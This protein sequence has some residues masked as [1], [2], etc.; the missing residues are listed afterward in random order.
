MG[1]TDKVAGCVKQ[2]AGDLMGKDSPA[3]GTQ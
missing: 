3:R 2:A 1:I